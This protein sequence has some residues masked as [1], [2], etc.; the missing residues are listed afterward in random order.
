[1]E[2]SPQPNFDDIALVRRDTTGRQQMYTEKE[3]EAYLS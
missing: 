1:M 2:Q 3:K